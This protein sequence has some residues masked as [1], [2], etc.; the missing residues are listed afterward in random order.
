[1]AKKKETAKDLVQYTYRDN[2]Q[3]FIMKRK[4]VSAIIVALLFAIAL[5]VFIAL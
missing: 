5:A 3:E 1:M 2:G 4:M